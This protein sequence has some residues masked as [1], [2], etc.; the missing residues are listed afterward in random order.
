MTSIEL[1]LSGTVRLKDTVGPGCGNHE[2][3]TRD[4][5]W[6]FIKLAFCYK[7]YESI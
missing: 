1:Q 2:Q 3:Y 5:D 7:T 4:L 6:A